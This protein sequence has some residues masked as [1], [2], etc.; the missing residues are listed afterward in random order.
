[1]F[2]LKRFIERRHSLWTSSWSWSDPAPVTIQG[3]GLPDCSVVTVRH[4]GKWSPMQDAFHAVRRKRLTES[5]D[6]ARLLQLLPSSVRSGQ[7]VT[8]GAHSAGHAPHK[9]G[10]P[11]I[12]DWAMSATRTLLRR[13]MVTSDR[14]VVADESAA[15]VT[16]E[17]AVEVRGLGGRAGQRSWGLLV[18]GRR[19]TE[20]RARLTADTR[21]SHASDSAPIANCQRFRRFQPTIHPR[22]QGRP[23]AALIDSDCWPRRFEHAAVA[24]A[25][26]VATDIR[27]GHWMDPVRRDIARS[28]SPSPR[29]IQSTPGPG[30]A[31]AAEERCVSGFLCW[32]TCRD[33][34]PS[35]GHRRTSTWRKDGPHHPRPPSPDGDKH[36]ATWSRRWTTLS[37]T[38]M[39]K[40]VGSTVHGQFQGD[41]WSTDDELPL[42]DLETSLLHPRDL[43]HQ[44]WRSHC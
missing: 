26:A 10:V 23:H 18:A 12:S 3:Y 2:A 20:A 16:G 24:D 15:D 17:V 40:H 22:L 31:A 35:G 27:V 39:T 5:P 4:R 25:A 11:V 43:P 7:R 37:T 42:Q 33:G 29:C 1:M 38:W 34:M 28:P 19:Q 36:R 6:Q 21:T 13:V 9:A 32:W 14:A 41:A 8:R 30:R 44:H